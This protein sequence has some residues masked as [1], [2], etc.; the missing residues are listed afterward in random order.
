M[1]RGMEVEEDKAIR[2]LTLRIAASIYL[3]FS[4]LWVDGN[5]IVCTGVW[6]VVHIICFLMGPLGWAHP[7]PKVIL[8]VGSAKP[9]SSMELKSSKGF[10]IQAGR[11]SLS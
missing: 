4:D 10:S 6:W 3:C 9:A 5:F 1:G 8:G 11:G 2:P 7:C